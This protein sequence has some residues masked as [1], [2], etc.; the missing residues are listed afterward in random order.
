[1]EILCSE[2]VSAKKKTIII[3]ELLEGREFATQ[4]KLILQKPV[5]VDESLLAVDL[6]EKILRS[7]TESISVLSSSEHGDE[8]GHRNLAVTGEN[9]SPVFASSDDRRSEE[10]NESWKRSSPQR[11]PTKD[12]RGCYKRRWCLIPYIIIFS[13]ICAFYTD[14]VTLLPQSTNQ[15]FSK[16]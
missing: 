3:R 8:A 9:G 6:L 13:L 10:S 5:G 15:Q 4:L 12:R 14:I 1:M 7:F 2:T 16:L 11:P